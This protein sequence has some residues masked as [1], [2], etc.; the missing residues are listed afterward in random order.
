MVMRESELRQL[1]RRYDEHLKESER[2][3]LE[4]WQRE[5]R[6]YAR[7]GKAPSIEAEQRLR[8]WGEIQGLIGRE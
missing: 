3:D 7:D 8:E 5:I 1:A 6:E 2:T 4:S